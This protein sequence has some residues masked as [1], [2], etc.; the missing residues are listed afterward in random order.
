MTH[1]RLIKLDAHGIKGIDCY[2]GLKI[3]LTAS[4]TFTVCIYVVEFLKAQ[5]WALCYFY[6]NDIPEQVECNISMFADDTKLYNAI[7]D[8][9]DTQR[10][11]ADLNSLAK[12]GK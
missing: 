12:W 5:F 6:V 3:F 2:H 7:K 9:A 11:Q 4:K 8:I 10:L 1:R